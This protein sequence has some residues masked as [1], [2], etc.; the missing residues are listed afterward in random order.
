MLNNLQHDAAAH[1]ALKDFR[2]KLQHILPRPGLSHRGKFLGVKVL[3]KPRP[4]LKPLRFRRHARIDANK[5]H[6]TQDEGRDAGSQV[7]ALRQAAGRDR[8]AIF[9]LRQSIGKRMATCGVDGTGPALAP[10]R[11]AGS[12]K[13]LPRDDLF[14]AERFE[15]CFLLPAGP[16][17][18]EPCSRASTRAR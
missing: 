16:L 17:K 12:R 8:A 2:R 15:V 14:C 4:G 3:S 5:G 13:L 6:A 10:E 7:H 18:P 11:L 9:G 1:F